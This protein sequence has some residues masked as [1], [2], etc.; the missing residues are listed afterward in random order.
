MQIMV[1]TKGLEH[2]LGRTIGKA[3][4]SREAS[5]D[6][7]DVPQ[8]RR[9]IAYSRKQRQKARAIEDPSTAAMEL[10]EKQQQP[11]VEDDVININDFPSGPHDTSVLRDFENHVVAFVDRRG[12]S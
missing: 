10:N 5:D 9:P 12:I 11:P 8:R 4:R 7:N 3:L 6:D 1:R 2:T